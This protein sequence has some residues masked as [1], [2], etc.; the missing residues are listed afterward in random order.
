MNDLHVAGGEKVLS[1]EQIAAHGK[2]ELFIPSKRLFEFRSHATAIFDDYARASRDGVREVMDAKFNL[3]MQLP[4]RFARKQTGAIASE[5]A[6]SPASAEQDAA[7]LHP[8]QRRLASRVKALIRAG[9]VPR[10]RRV[11][12]SLGVADS[13]NPEVQDR[14]RA[15]HPVSD[16]QLP[17]LPDGAPKISIPA[18][19]AFK[20]F[21]HRAPKSSAGGLSGW[22]YPMLT[23]LV[24]EGNACP[25]LASL[26]EDIANGNV[27]NASQELLAAAKLLGLNKPNG[28]VRPLALGEVF[29]RLAATHA[30]RSNWAEISLFAGAFDLAFGRKG[31]AEIAIHAIRATLVESNKDAV[32]SIDITN[33]FNTRSRAHVL[34]SVFEEKSLSGVWRIFDA[35]YKKS[36]KLLMKTDNG[37]VEISSSTGTRQGDVL[38]G[39]GFAVSLKKDIIVAKSAAPN[40]TVVSYLDNVYCLAPPDDCLKFLNA[41]TNEAKQNGSIVDPAKSS[42][43]YFHPE[44]LPAAVTDE[45]KKL[46]LPLV[47]DVLNVMGTDVHKDGS[48]DEKYVPASVAEHIEMLKTLQLDCYPVQHA[49]LL[50]RPSAS[51]A[52][53]Y[54]ARTLPPVKLA[55]SA[56][57]LEQAT[58]GFL[59]SKLALNAQSPLAFDDMQKE[60]IQLS[61]SNGG[62]GMRSLSRISAPAYVASVANAAPFLLETKR[63]TTLVDQQAASAWQDIESRLLPEDVPR[64]VLLEEESHVAYYG[65]LDNR[66]LPL[67]SSLKMQKELNKGLKKAEK[68]VFSDVEDYDVARFD[69]LK[70]PNASRFLTVVPTEPAL[71]LKDSEMRVAVCYRLGA[72]QAFSSAKNL[73][74]ACGQLLAHD[75]FH[76]VGC[77]RHPHSKVIARHDAVKN[78]LVKWIKKSG[79]VAAAE[80]REYSSSLERNIRPDFQ[81]A[82]GATS[83]VGD[84]V[85]MNPAAPSNIGKPDCMSATA[86]RKVNKFKH[87]V[88]KGPGQSDKFVPCVFETFGG[89]S[90]DSVALIDNIGKEVRGE[91]VESADITEGLISEVAVAIQRGNAATI[92]NCI[93]EALMV[94][95]DAGSE[96]PATEVSIESIE[97]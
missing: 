9:D 8:Q 10:A 67:V 54:T 75:S 66:G 45:L 72:T 37:F 81:C 22:T 20:R 43:A 21:L 60:Q 1:V 64:L 90:K 69:A 12:T 41:F 73:Q 34:R 95:A 78:A 26:I 55:P 65:Q 36:G 3:I 85:V 35:T 63:S 33:A 25:G 77:N 49:L 17:A 97:L 83:I 57:L 52:L 88:G 74:C 84:I 94:A 27:S 28:G 5:S 86:A 93:Q 44:L 71:I 31:G 6:P 82:L 46:N 56:K 39:L 19:R 32:L 87:F 24:G 62:L 16:E 23:A 53:V 61:L 96:V 42:L 48:V 40:A 4:D 18:D 13:S 2:L 80:P 30:V 76:G 70:R 59:Q 91:G 89:F 50:A 92:L 51:T 38:G 47:T 15:L 7:G 68:L 14:L 79:N 11:L 58:V 29:H